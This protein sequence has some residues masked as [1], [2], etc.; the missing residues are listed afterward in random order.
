MPDGTDP[1]TSGIL[2][3]RKP[4]GLT[5]HDVVARV[6]RLTGQKSVGHAG[7]LDPLA[8][9]VLV[10]LLGRGTA[11]SAYAT[12][13]T[14][15]YAAEVVFGVATETDDAE[16]RILGEVEAPTMGVEEM[17]TK[18]AGLTGKIMQ[19]PPSYS[20]VKVAGEPSHRRLRRGETTLLGPRP[21]CIS[22]IQILSWERPRLRLK[23][24]TGPGVY[25]RSLARD[26][27]V[28][29]KSAAY[30]HSLVRLASGTFSIQDSVPLESLTAETLSGHLLPVDSVV[31][32]LPAVFLSDDQTHSVRHGRAIDLCLDE[33]ARQSDL[34]NVRIYGSEGKLVALGRIEGAVC[35]PF[36][37][38]YPA[39]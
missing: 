24:T 37:V 21:V 28:A 35:K 23:V 12:G 39:A 8:T 38:L 5:S 15:L 32:N 16:G 7:T 29:L 20:A 2:N 9:G 10:I 6:R 19:I 11:L 22:D 18:L 27:G 3:L 36:R 33:Q 17:A 1:V 34:H 31:L 4:V 30:L 26:I 13:S 25:I 14:K